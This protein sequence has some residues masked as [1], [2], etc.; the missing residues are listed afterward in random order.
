[1]AKILS[2]QYQTL[3]SEQ[4]PM[5]KIRIDQLQH[6]WGI[7]EF[8]FSKENIINWIDEP[9]NNDAPGPDDFPVILLKKCK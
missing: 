4:I 3:F 6:T 5:E 1:M 8:H 2:R 7:T 9:S